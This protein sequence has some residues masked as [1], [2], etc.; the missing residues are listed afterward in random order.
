MSDSAPF[1]NPLIKLSL[2]AL[3]R[4]YGATIHIYSK[5]YETI[6][7]KTGKL[8]VDGEVYTV[9]LAVILPV[10]TSRDVKRTISNISANKFFVMGGF[11]DDSVRE[12]IIDRADTPGLDLTLDDWIVYQGRKYILKEINAFEFDA[13]WSVIG[14]AVSGAVP[15]QPTSVES[16][17]SLELGD[18]TSVSEP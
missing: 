4:Q 14:E 6:D 3:K 5:S 12:F 11:Y 13:A 2:Y 8:T 17:Q 7:P 10:K 15:A 16:S 9:D 1:L 18:S